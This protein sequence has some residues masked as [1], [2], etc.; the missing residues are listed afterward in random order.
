M[1]DSRV[2]KKIVLDT[3]SNGDKSAMKI[4]EYSIPK[5]DISSLYISVADIHS[6][7]AV[8][9]L[10]RNI[11]P[12]DPAV[13]EILIHAKENVDLANEG[14]SEFTKRCKTTKRKT[15]DK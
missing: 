9:G 13:E 1:L 12:E 10:L 3:V 2:I 11:Y 8:S 5:C 14:V 7:R 4:F 15:S 6:G